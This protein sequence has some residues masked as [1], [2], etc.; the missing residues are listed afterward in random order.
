MNMDLETLQ[1]PIGRFKWPSTV[2]EQEI[3]DSINRI[4]SLPGK[5]KMATENLRDDQ[6]DIPYREHGWT[7][8][9]V[10]HHIADSHMNAYIR[11][12]L[13]LTEDKPTIKPYDEAK[14]A[15]LSD[16]IT[17]R[18]DISL[19]ILKGVHTRW[20]AIMKCMPGESWDREY[21]HPEHNKAYSLKQAV[22]MYAWHG[23]HHLA[24]ITGLLKRN[25]E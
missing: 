17:L 4:E 10:V 1:Y 25:A 2:S 19:A 24:H 21:I 20:V 11:F 13:A 23:D 16:S 3:Q 15:M 8:R 9:Q 5:I 18:A 6:L 14:W 7:I 22:K 12:K